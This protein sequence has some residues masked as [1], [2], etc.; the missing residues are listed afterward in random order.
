MWIW[1]SSGAGDSAAKEDG[2]DSARG[3]LNL[4]KVA[5]IAPG[6][7]GT[8]LPVTKGVYERLVE[9]VSASTRLAQDST[10]RSLSSPALDGTTPVLAMPVRV[11]GRRREAAVECWAAIV[12]EVRL[13]STVPIAARG[14]IS[15]DAVLSAPEMSSRKGPGGL[16]ASTL[17]SL[18]KT[19]SRRS[20]LGP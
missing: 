9:I 13:C 4:A 18:T 3:V 1:I 10:R 17:S 19:S 6:V 5:S 14:W 2:D 16:A 12:P 20:C 8:I 15:D 7:G 11:E